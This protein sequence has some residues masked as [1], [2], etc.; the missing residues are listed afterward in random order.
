VK[1]GFAIIVKGMSVKHAWDLL[2]LRMRARA[3]LPKNVWELAGA[4]VE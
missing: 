3:I 4:S 2:D 1:V